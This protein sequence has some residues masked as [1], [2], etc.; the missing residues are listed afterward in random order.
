MFAYSSLNAELLPSVLASKLFDFY[1]I[2]DIR[3][4]DVCEYGDGMTV[5][6]PIGDTCHHIWGRKSP[7]ANCTSYACIARQEEIVK[8]EELDGKVLLI[9][10]VPVEIA[11]QKY[12]LELI[13]DAT[14]SLMVPSPVKRDNI[15]IIQMVSQFNDLAVHDSF[16]KLYNKTFIANQLQVVLDDSQFD[17]NTPEIERPALVMF[18][19]DRFK[20]INDEYGHITGDIVLKYLADVL[21]D[22]A[23]KFEGGWAGRFGGDEFVVCAPQGLG[24]NGQ[25]HI[26][27]SVAE[28]CKHA[29][30][31]TDY[32]FS[33]SLS[34]GISCAQ[35]DDTYDAFV[36]RAD[37]ELYS[38]KEQNHL[39]MDLQK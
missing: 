32:E 18:D 7:C 25:T 1:R 8:I 26:A 13:K 3:T 28:F 39:V 15:E 19:L 33:C 11:G 16:T 35:V 36:E 10:S 21:S 31:D 24:S 34:Y 5:P 22:L 12:A 27:M 4:H 20:E 6:V 23:N 14:T 2:V 30:V 38:M 17:E 29:F 37:R 9:F